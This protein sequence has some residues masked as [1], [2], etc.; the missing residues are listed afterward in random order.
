MIDWLIVM[1]SFY[2]NHGNRKTMVVLEGLLIGYVR[3]YRSNNS[4]NSGSNFMSKE[5]MRKL[6]PMILKRIEERSKDYPVKAMTPVAQ[7]VLKS[8]NLLINGV[9]TLLHFIPV[10]ACKYYSLSFL[11]TC[12]IIKFDSI[13]ICTPPF[14]NEHPIFDVGLIFIQIIFLLSNYRECYW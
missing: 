11:V 13:I 10:W 8:R 12:I 14:Q 9:S 4:R 7:E 1:A 6:R 5:N 2:W 3:N